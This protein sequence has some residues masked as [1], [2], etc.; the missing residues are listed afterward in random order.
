MN[1]AV[2]CFN[3]SRTKDNYAAD[4]KI[5]DEDNTYIC[6]QTEQ[7]SIHKLQIHADAQVSKQIKQQMGDK[8]PGSNARESKQKEQLSSQGEGI[9]VDCLFQTG[10]DGMQAQLSQKIQQ[11]LS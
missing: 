11:A 4:N 5:Q 7:N 3:R 10:A 2:W 6:N 8:G 1:H 9:G